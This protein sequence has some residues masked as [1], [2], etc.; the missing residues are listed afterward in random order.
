MRVWRLSLRRTKSAIISWVGSFVFLCQPGSIIERKVS[1]QYHPEDQQLSLADSPWLFN[2]QHSSVQQINNKSI[3]M[4]RF[5]VYMNEH[6]SEENVFKLPVVTL[7]TSKLY[8]LEAA[9]VAFT[10]KHKWYMAL[11]NSSSLSCSETKQRIIKNLNKAS[12]LKTFNLVGARCSV[13]VRAHRGSIVGFLLVQRFSVGLEYWSCFISVLN[14]DLYV[15]C[16]GVLMS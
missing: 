6:I 8:F 9:Q 16:F 11:P 5:D 1:I 7:K 2:I 12:G 14:L 4:V 13:F 10:M 15:C 3:K